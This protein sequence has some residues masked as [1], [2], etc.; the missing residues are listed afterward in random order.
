MSTPDQATSIAITFGT[1]GFTAQIIDS[2]ISGF[3]RGDVDTTHSGTTP[4]S[5]TDAVIRT[6]KPSDIVEGGDLNLT[7]HFLPDDTI[8]LYGAAETITITFPTNVGEST[9]ATWVF[10][11]Y[12]KAYNPTMNPLDDSTMQA[13]VTVKI[14]GEIT[15]T[16]AGT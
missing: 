5:G 2:N 6:Y 8:P 14:A 10:S 11:G 16:P 9:G 4:V 12:I 7:I 1:S 3:Q 15:I 13:S